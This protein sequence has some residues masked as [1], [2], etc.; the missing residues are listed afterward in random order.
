MNGATITMNDATDPKSRSARNWR[1]HFDRETWLAA[2]LGFFGLLLRAKICFS[3]NLCATPDLGPLATQLS[4][5]CGASLNGATD[6]VVASSGRIARALDRA[7]AKQCAA[8]D[9]FLLVRQQFLRSADRRGRGASH[10][11]SADAFQST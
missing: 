3:L 6:L 1:E 9:D 5:G 7:N 4:F 10:S 8:D 2:G 11:R